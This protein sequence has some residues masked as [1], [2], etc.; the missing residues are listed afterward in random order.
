MYIENI[1]IGQPLINE[2]ILLSDENNAYDN[3]REITVYDSERFL[4]RLLVKYNF[5]KSI[6]EIRRNRADLLIYL[7]KPDFFKIKLG[8]KI[9]WVVV[10]E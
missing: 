2:K 9:I 4:P 8:K 7:D 5:V 10:G 1:V 6:K 3:W